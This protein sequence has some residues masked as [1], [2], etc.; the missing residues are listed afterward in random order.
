MIFVRGSLRRRVTLALLRH[1]MD[2]DGA[3]LIVAHIAQHRQKVIEGVTVDRADVIKAKLLEQRAAGYV[4]ARMCHGAGNGAVD[5]LAEIGRQF[6]AEIAETHIGAAGGQPRQI[7]AHRARRRRNRHIVIVEDDDQPRIERAG[8]VERLKR[9]ARRHRAVA[10]DGDHLAVAAFETCRHRHAETGG[11]GGGGMAGAEIVIVAFRTAG[12]AGKPVFLAQRADAVTTAGQD[13]V[14]ITLVADIEDQSVFRRVEDLVDGNR[15]FHHAEAGPQM[16]TGFRHGVN[17]LVAQFPR[18]FRQVAIVDL[19]EIG[20][21][22]HPVEQW[23][24]WHSGQSF[25]LFLSSAGRARAAFM[26]KANGS[27]LHVVH[28]Y[29]IST[30]RQRDKLFFVAGNN[31]E[32]SGSPLL[33]GLFYAFF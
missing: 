13:L 29:R 6:L 28:F 25:G 12:E 7:G 26:V 1:H 32:A 18:Q 15:Q 11:N 3:F 4:T 14:R 5:S 9:H 31:I 20:G 27:A 17:H 19:L 22:I 10:D 30:F 16:A 24:L 21:K 2:E 33:F 23:C 8:I